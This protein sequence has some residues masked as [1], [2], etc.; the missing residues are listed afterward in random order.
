MYIE[1]THLHIGTRQ[2]LIGRGT[3]RKENEMK[4][5]S[6]KLKG[7]KDTEKVEEHKRK[8]LVKDC[9]YTHAQVCV[10]GCVSTRLYKVVVR[11]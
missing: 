2:R 3:T 10:Q 5:Q 4:G 9:A 7:E 11:V 6:N 8:H 1:A